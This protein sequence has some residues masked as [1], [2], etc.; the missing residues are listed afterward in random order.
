MRSGPSAS[1]RADHRASDRSSPI[2]SSCVA[3]PPSRTIGAP[4]PRASTKASACMGRWCHGG[5]VRRVGRH[6]PRRR[7]T[8]CALEVEGQAQREAT[9]QPRDR[10]HDH[11]ADADGPADHARV[12]LRR[13]FIAM[14]QG[15]HGAGACAQLDSGRS[16]RVGGVKRS[17]PATP[18][19]QPSGEARPA[20]LQGTH[21]LAA[22]TL[23]RHAS[24]R[25]HRRSATTA[26]MVPRRTP[27]QAL[28]GTA[29]STTRPS[30]TEPEIVPS[31]C[32][33]PSSAK[34]MSLVRLTRL[35]V[36]TLA[37]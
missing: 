7:Q 36:W 32:A 1:R 22:R 15:T 5:H 16:D 6:R 33:P 31:W 18:R 13:P 14:V 3:R 37:S 25:I 35:N 8:R 29:S 17:H 28:T 12:G 23:H 30:A 19:L 9:A 26:S 4:E 20:I 10:E 11:P 21:R 24:G 2:A 34:T 27:S